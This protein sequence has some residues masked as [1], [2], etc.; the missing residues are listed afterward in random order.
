MVIVK[1]IYEK[2][3]KG[4]RNIVQK[5]TIIDKKKYNVKYTKDGHNETEWFT[6]N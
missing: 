5:G 3:K 2:N 6:S 1:R 4:K